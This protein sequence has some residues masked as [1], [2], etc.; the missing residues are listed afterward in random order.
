MKKKYNLLNMMPE[1]FS[2][3]ES[4]RIAHNRFDH[5]G[6]HWWNTWIPGIGTEGNK[7]MEKELDEVSDYM[8]R[9]FP[10][11]VSDMRKF[12]QNDGAERL[13]DDEYNLY[14]VGDYT[15][16]WIRLI[17]RKGDYNMYIKFFKKTI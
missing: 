10:K 8:R 7:E 17:L 5:D 4:L 13:S 9:L 1:H 16:V 12:V 2:A 14:I 11:G 3:D 6:Y 15:N